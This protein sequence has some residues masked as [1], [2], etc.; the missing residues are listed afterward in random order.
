MN[1]WASQYQGR[2]QFVGVHSNRQDSV[3]DIRSYRDEHN[4]RF[5]LVKDDGNAIADQFGAER[6]PEVFVVDRNLAV[7]YQGRIDDQYSPGI[8]RPEPKRQDL[9]VAIDQLLSGDDVEMPKTEA[10]GCLI[11]RIKQ[12]VVESDVTY[13]GQIARILQRNCLECHRSGEI[14]PFAM[15]D[16]DE[17]VGWADMILEVVQD[18]RMP[19]W[20]AN[21]SFG[22][23]ANERMLSAM[24]KQQLEQWV[25]AGAPYGDESDLPDNVEFTDGW[26]CQSNPTW[27]CR[28]EIVHLW[29]RRMAR[30]SISISLS[31]LVLKKTSG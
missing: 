17:V 16:F 2:V 14:G 1:A 28:C 6:T 27:C 24:E 31:I 9:R 23:F 29:S 26:R 20:H 3:D 8:A 21:P 19:P 7:Q 11:G 12:P 30:L 25:A 22:H 4:L 18:G 5:P 10:V 15:N 13:C